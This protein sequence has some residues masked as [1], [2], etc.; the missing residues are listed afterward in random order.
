MFKHPS[1]AASPVHTPVSFELSSWAADDALQHM[2]SVA[3]M[4]ISQVI[5]TP[6]C[7]SCDPAARSKTFIHTSYS[8]LGQ[9]Q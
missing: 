3:W 1:G 2:P 9:E 5:W 4:L 7:C 8:Y 6:V